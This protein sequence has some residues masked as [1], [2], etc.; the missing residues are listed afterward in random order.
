MSDKTG[1]SDC[2][3][4]NNTKVTNPKD[5][6]EG[7]CSYFTNVGRDLASQIPNP[8]KPYT[9]YLKHRNKNSIFFRPT[10]PFEI[11]KIVTKMKAKKSSWCDDISCMFLKKLKDEYSYQLACLSIS[12]LEVE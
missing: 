7:F 2:F 6:S 9:T 4:V 10:D 12:H 1:V 11:Y 3:S 5:I 8:K